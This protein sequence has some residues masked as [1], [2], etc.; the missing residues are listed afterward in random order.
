[1]LKDGKTS[2]VDYAYLLGKFGAH[3]VL[4]NTFK[5]RSKA[6]EEI[7]VQED[8]I[9]IIEQQLIAAHVGQSA[10]FAPVREKELISGLLHIGSLEKRE[11]MTKSDFERHLHN[12]INAL[13]DFAE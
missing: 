5:L 12:Q 9:D 3:A 2:D 10:A 8:N 7:T 6:Y 4:K 1:M 13:F 11:G